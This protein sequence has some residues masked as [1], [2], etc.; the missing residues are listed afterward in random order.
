MNKQLNTE[1]M[2]AEQIKDINDRLLKDADLLC[3]DKD[4][5]RAYFQGARD[6]N[7]ALYMNGII[8]YKEYKILI[9]KM[10]EEVDKLLKSN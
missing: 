9:D 6:I 7:H 8:D 10:N 1:T 3:N 5:R 4:Q 2:K